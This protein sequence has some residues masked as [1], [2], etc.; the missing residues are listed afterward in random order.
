MRLSNIEFLIEETLRSLGRNAIITAASISTTALTLLVVG[1]I[2]IAMV[3]IEYLSQSL[4]GKLDIAVFLKPGASLTQAEALAERVKEWEGVKE[5][6]VVP[7][8]EAWRDL[9][10]ELQKEVDLSDIPN[11]LPHALRLRV[12]SPERIITIA[13]TLRQES[14]VEEV[15]AGEEIAEK[16]RSFNRVL[17]LVGAILGTVLFVASF[18]II[19]NAIRLAIYARRQEIRIMQLV[20]ATDAFIAAP[21]ILEGASYG[22]LGGALAYLLLLLSYTYAENHFPLAFVSL[23]PSNSLWLPLLLL[24]LPFGIFIGLLSS[25][26]STL[27]FLSQRR[28]EFE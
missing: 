14:M 20:G 25:C 1:I 28:E 27:Y 13:E 11:P 7:K 26:L 8:E 2:V 24:I 6:K 10:K 22:L 18:V 12:D 23:L 16:L 4:P 9:R 21:F 3:H 17:K 19:G 5:A 15:R